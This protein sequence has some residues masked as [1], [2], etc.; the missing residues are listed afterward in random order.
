MPK[1][2]AT[3]ASLIRAGL[4]LNDELPLD[5]LFA[6]VT[7]AA[8]AERA[9][10]TTGSFF[11]HFRN[12][13]EFAA[14]LVGSYDHERPIDPEFIDQI[15]TSISGAAITDALAS[16][17]AGSW[18]VLSADPARRAERRGQMHL[19]AHHLTSLPH[20][21]D[22][23]DD[24]ATALRENTS[25]DIANQAAGTGAVG[26]GAA[27]TGAVGDVLRAVYRTQIDNTTAIWEGLLDATEMRLD[28]PFDVRRLATAVHSLMLGMEIVHQLDPDAIDD[29]LFAETTS[30]LATS[31]SRLDF[32]A[33]R[34]VVAAELGE[35]PVASPQARSGARRRHESRLKVLRAVDG[36]FDRGWDS[37]SATDVAEAA[38]VSTQTVINLFGNVRRVCAAT[39]VRHL[40]AFQ[41]A[42]DGHGP[43]HPT[44]SV[45]SALNV[46]ARA[47]AD[48]PHPARALLAERV[49][50]RSERGFDLDDDDIRVLVPLGIRLTRPLSA[51]MGWEL[52]S[53]ALPDLGS[54]L[55]E[56]VLGNAIPRP[57][58]SEETVE[59]ALRLLPL[60]GS[61]APSIFEPGMSRDFANFPNSGRWTAPRYSDDP[62]DPDDEPG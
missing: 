27:G 49:G 15:R 19:F 53:L 28:E 40:P 51:V 13:S 23:S 7:T 61:A 12:A 32:R 21:T 48:D 52:T 43:D 39:F 36:M 35:D 46:L 47:A 42:I 5:R 31:V 3:R 25:A 58:R 34:V 57:G 11:H 41:A 17:L 60:P 33:P 22:Q 44:E 18:Q 6:G 2:T 50:A 54:T 62:S 45:A 4:E 24:D 29:L 30:R 20:P 8:A 9:G 38:N 10:V 55:I 14:A 1:G 59:L 56:F 16:V 37:V 26:E